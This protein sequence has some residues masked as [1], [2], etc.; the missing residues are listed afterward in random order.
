MDGS[1]GNRLGSVKWKL[2][3]GT[4]NVQGL[5]ARFSEVVAEIERARLDLVVLTETMKKGSGSNTEGNY[6][7]F[8]QQSEQG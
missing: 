8:F 7:H 3:Y 4:W 6:W 2:A 1:S 5:N